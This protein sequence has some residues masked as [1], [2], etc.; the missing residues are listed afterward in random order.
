[1]NHPEFS[2]LGKYTMRDYRLDKALE[3]ALPILPYERIEIIY[4]K[5]IEPETPLFDG[6]HTI[7]TVKLLSKNEIEK[8][9]QPTEQNQ[10]KKK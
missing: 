4:P 7:G 3:D 2:S 5:P 6:I 9:C 8:I 1:M 10:K